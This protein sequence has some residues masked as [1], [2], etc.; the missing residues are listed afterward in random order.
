MS[1]ITRRAALGGA[2]A[3]ALIGYATAP[4]ALRAAQAINIP[5]RPM[6]LL[7]RLERGMRGGALITVEREW[8]IEFNVQGSGFAIVGEQVSAKVDAPT[9][10]APLA[11]LER[12]RST[13]GMFPIL[14]VSNGSIAATGDF[15][16][17]HDVATA[18]KT[19]KMMI[20]ER[21]IPSRAK[22]QQ[23]QY[24]TSLQSA[25][26]SFLNRLPPDLFFPTSEPFHSIRPVSLPDGLVGEF[27]VTY[28]A[29]PFLGYGWLKRAERRVLTR[30]GNSERQSRETWS[31]LPI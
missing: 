12:S 1:G 24:L 29:Q 7:R 18:L 30:V 31:M 25:G 28:R 26:A 13:A 14:L 3:T 5:K 10:L 11:D 21:S 23:L 22:S 4:A 16:K 19:A 8:R 2:M 17:P 20:A 6:R 15:T 27:E 9:H